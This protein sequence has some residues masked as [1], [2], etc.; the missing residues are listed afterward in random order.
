MFTTFESLGFQHDLLV[1]QYLA[2][3]KNKTSCFLACHVSF[4]EHDHELNTKYIID[5]KNQRSLS[6]S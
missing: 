2:I 4:H 6:N 1:L 3:G 5:N